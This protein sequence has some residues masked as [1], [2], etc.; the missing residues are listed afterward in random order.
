MISY[1]VDVNFKYRL[2]E[3]VHTVV[4]GGFASL[5]NFQFISTRGQVCVF[6]EHTCLKSALT[7][8]NILH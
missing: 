5:S 2:F 7:E 3:A 4:R 6:K 8:G 1:V